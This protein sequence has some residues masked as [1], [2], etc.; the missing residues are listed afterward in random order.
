MSY[1]IFQLLLRK[2]GGGATQGKGTNQ[3]IALP[4]RIAT[5]SEDR[6]AQFPCRKD[7]WSKGSF[8]IRRLRWDPRGSTDIK[9]RNAQTAAFRH[10]DHEIILLL[11]LKIVICYNL[12]EQYLQSEMGEGGLFPQLAQPIC[13]LSWDILLNCSLQVC[14]WPLPTHSFPSESTNS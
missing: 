3:K 7:W 4:L 14:L 12:W 6:C 11:A 10:Q 8:S 9:S 5:V 13:I 2:G 1:Q